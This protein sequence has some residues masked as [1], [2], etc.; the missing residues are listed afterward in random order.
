MGTE[1][2]RRLEPGK[3]ADAQENGAEASARMRLRTT[4][5]LEKEEGV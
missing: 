4:G 1:V 2:A 5:D 3:H